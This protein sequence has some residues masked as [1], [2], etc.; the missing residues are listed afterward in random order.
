MVILADAVPPDPDSVALTAPVVLFFTPALVEKTFTEKVQLALEASVPPVKVILLDPAVAVITPSPHV[1]VSPFGVAT[2]NPA[3]RLSVNPT[4]VS[5]IPLL[6][7][8]I[9][10]L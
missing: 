2:T 7:L 10:K 5:A 1:P 9:V 4:P 8:L 3:G 6:G